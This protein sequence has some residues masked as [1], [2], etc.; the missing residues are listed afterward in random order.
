[1]SYPAKTPVNLWITGT[2]HQDCV[3]SVHSMLSVGVS[4]WS[5]LLLW[6]ESSSSEVYV[7]QSLYKISS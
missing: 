1:L 2:P 7:Y 6:G 5:L 4:S 3:L